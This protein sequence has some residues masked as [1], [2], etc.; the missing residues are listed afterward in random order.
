MNYNGFPNTLHS[1]KW[2]IVL[3]N[4]P[5]LQ[6]SSDMRYFENYLKSCTIPNYTMG[7]ILSQLPNGMQVRHPLG[8]MKKNQDLGNLN[9]TFKLS[10][11]M[12]NYLIL[13]V[14]MMQMRYG[15]IDPR[16]DG[17][18]REYTIKRLTVQML[19]NQKRTIAEL[20]FT[21]LFLLDLGS[22]DLNFGSS[23]EIAFT[24]SFSYEEI[25]YDLKNPMIG[26]TS[27]EAPVNITECGTSGIP[28]NPDLDW[29]D[30]N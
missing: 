9:L 19:D 29:D 13:F 15:Q 10:E 27:L 3:S 2:R 14:W 28:I 16:H 21:N 30:N 12:Y 22:L 4:I 6:D 23:E 24:T 7:E 5:T 25:I 8:G 11:D 17:Y 26:G 18:F 1:D 20:A